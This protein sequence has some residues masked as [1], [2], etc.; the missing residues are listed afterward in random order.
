MQTFVV[1]REFCIHWLV[2]RG[3]DFFEKQKTK[4]IAEII[5]DFERKAAAFRF[6]LAQVSGVV[7]GYQK[8]PKLT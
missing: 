3:N 7:R 2:E 1:W 5:V 8:G 6:Y 4:D